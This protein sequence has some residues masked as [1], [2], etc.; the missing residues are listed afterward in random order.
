MITHLGL[1][2]SWATPHTRGSTSEY[3]AVVKVYHGYPAY[4]GIDL[5]FRKPNMR[6]RRLPRIR[7]DRPYSSMYSFILAGATPHT[8]GSTLVQDASAYSYAGYPAYAGIDP[9]QRQTST[10]PNGL[11]RIRGDRPSLSVRYS[12]LSWATPHTRGSTYV[13]YCALA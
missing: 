7:G 2:L 5:R 3:H 12:T 4:A 10:I 13:V 1:K 8:R 9:S 6:K 11:P